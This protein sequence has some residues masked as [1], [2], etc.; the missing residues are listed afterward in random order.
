MTTEKGRHFTN[1]KY[2]EMAVG[3]LRANHEQTFQQTLAVGHLKL[4]AEDYSVYLNRIPD[5]FL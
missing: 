3:I 2:Y 1:E 4:Y 5:L